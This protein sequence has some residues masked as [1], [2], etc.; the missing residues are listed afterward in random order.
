MAAKKKS[1]LAAVRRAMVEQAF[2]AGRRAAPAISVGPEPIPSREPDRFVEPPSLGDNRD[3]QADFETDGVRWWS[4]HRPGGLGVRR[5]DGLTHYF[6]WGHRGGGNNISEEGARRWM[7]DNLRGKRI[8]NLSTGFEVHMARVLGV[9]LEGLGC[10]ASDVAHWAAFIDDHRREFSLE[11]LCRDYLP[12]DERKVTVVNGVRLDMSKAMEYPA[13]VMAVRA[14]A[15]VRQVGLLMP[16]LWKELDR[17]GLQRVRALEDKV[18]FAACEM[19]MNAAPLDMEKL[20]CWVNE[21]AEELDL[22]RR[23]LAKE[24]GEGVQEGLFDGAPA[25]EAFN[26]DSGKQMEALFRRLNLPLA[27]TEGKD[28]KPGR[29]SFTAEVLGR[30]AGHPTIDAIVRMGRLLDLRA[31]YLLPYHTA[32]LKNDGFLR[33]KLHQARGDEKGTVRGRFSASGA[34]GVTGSSVQQVMKPSKQRKTLGPKYVVRELFIARPGERVVS[35]DAMQIEYRIFASRTGSKKLEAAYAANPML[36][37]HEEIR[38]LIEPYRPDVDYDKA[39]TL[40]FL[41]I[42]GGG[43]AKL[44]MELKYITRSQFAALTEEYKNAKYGIPR[45]HPLLKETMAVRKVYE[46]AIPEVG[47]LSKWARGLVADQGYVTDVLGRRATF[48]GGF[49]AHAALNAII[50]PD[51]AEVMKTKMVEVHAVRKELGLRPQMTVHD[52]WMGAC[53]TAEAARALKE[54]LN[55]QSFP[56]FARIPILWDVKVGKDWASCT[57][58]LEAEFEAGRAA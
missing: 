30:H 34:D 43:P 24:L 6:A 35:A 17:L 31:K 4:G 25:G 14:E 19:E 37:F 3:V 27:Y 11:A 57:S 40:N 32:G 29:P 51:A 20:G 49:G 52:E 45:D 1:A 56:E 7:I 13:S 33:Y 39:K 16:I 18:I 36:Q 15:D 23:A 10:E 26:P 53:S 12:E 21:S 8:T 38:R 22:M 5:S 54:V 41:T 44:A 28:G 47:P 46:R 9:D 42:Y 2:L 50:Q 58:E 48:P 55:R